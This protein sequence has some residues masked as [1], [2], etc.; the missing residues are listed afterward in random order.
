MWV[1][2]STATY[3]DDQTEHEEYVAPFE[4]AVTAGVA[5]IP[6]SYNQIN[7]TY[8]CGRQSTLKKIPRGE[9]G[10]KGL[11]TSEPGPM[12]AP[13]RSSTPCSRPLLTRI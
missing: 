10:F 11:V 8:A 2:D 5:S 12:L 9:I 6:C 13:C 4:A 1:S 7:G 3:I